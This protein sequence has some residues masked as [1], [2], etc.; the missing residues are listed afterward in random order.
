M[1]SPITKVAIAGA[2]GALGSVVTSELVKAGFQI[3]AL[4]RDASKAKLPADVKAVSV[5]YDDLSSLKSALQGQ[6]ALVST[7]GSQGIGQ[8][9][10][11]VDAALAIGVQ[12][13]IP[14]EFGS[15]H[16]TPEARALPVYKD[17]VDLE[18]YLAEKTVG[19]RTSYTIVTNNAFLDWGIERGFLINVKE[20]KATIYDG[21]DIPWTATPLYM[22]GQA[23]AGI[24]KK[25]QETANR[26][27]KIHGASLT[28][29]HLLKLVQEVVGNEGWQLEQWDTVERVK[30]AYA[31]LQADP[32]NVYA[33]LL[34]MIFRAA[35]GRGMLT[36]WAEKN[37]NALVG[38]KAL[39]DEELRG[40]VREEA[41]KLA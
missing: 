14:S 17:K 1:S 35:V 37:D 21:G 31:T 15:D 34:P 32:G 40:I 19:T 25:P 2:T 6:D 26:E 41:T 3:T 38:I 28:S 36:D 27:V 11:L 33:W 18:E 4:T 8:Q 10:L 30:Q 20:R 29:N 12:K 16:T 7:L 39:T 13:I 9:K 22:I 5:D 23:V 24:L